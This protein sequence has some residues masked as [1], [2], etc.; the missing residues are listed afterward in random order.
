LVEVTTGHSVAASTP[1]WSCAGGCAAAAARKLS[2]PW[3][4]RNLLKG[5]DTTRK[6][7]GLVYLNQEME[8]WMKN[9]DMLGLVCVGASIPMPGGPLLSFEVCNTIL[10]ALR[11]WALEV[12]NYSFHLLRLRFFAY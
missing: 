1:A 8:L 4:S 9:S 5:E 11:D 7:K 3:E 6:K 12:Q 2:W 10:E